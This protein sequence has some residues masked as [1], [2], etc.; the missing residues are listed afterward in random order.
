MPTA[1]D[2]FSSDVVNGIIYAVGGDGS[3]GV[4][5][6]VEAYN[7]ATDTWTKKASLP[8]TRF[9]MSVNAVNGIIYAIGGFGIPSI[10]EAYDPMTDTWTRKA[11]MPTNRG[12]HSASAVNGKIY[13]IGGGTDPSSGSPLT[14]G[15]VEEYD[16]FR[17]P[18]RLPQGVDAK[19]KIATLWGGLKAT[20]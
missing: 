7:P 1:R 10:V 13:A 14:E 8:S 6:E 19:G 11:D 4:H 17:A 12:Y 2:L 18:R 20:K 9:G 16:I 3:T 15:V 5:A